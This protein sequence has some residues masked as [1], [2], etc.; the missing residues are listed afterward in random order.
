MLALVL[1]VYSISTVRSVA[2]RHG[3]IYACKLCM[4]VL[5]IF[6]AQRYM[7]KTF[8]YKND[9]GYRYQLLY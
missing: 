4:H 9:I 8:R 6:V 3:D 2:I 5:K 1:N 7:P